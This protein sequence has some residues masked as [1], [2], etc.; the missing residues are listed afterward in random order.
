MTPETRGAS[1]GVTIVRAIIYLGYITGPPMSGNSHVMA[2]VFG[3]QYA[4]LWC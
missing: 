4:G 3:P 2:L 1:L